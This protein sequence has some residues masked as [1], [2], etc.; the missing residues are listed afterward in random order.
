MGRTMNEKGESPAAFRLSDYFRSQRK[1]PIIISAAY[2]I[3]VDYTQQGTKN[4]LAKLHI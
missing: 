3:E 2:S 4:A 1:F